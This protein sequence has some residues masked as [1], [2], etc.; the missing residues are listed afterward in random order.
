MKNI[1]ITVDEEVAKWARLWAA[2]HD[3]SVS[4]LVGELL[5]ERMKRESRYESAMRKYLAKR[6][7]AISDGRPYPGRDELHDRTRLR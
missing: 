7:T 2:K 6:P 1:T 5:E 4:R 3:T